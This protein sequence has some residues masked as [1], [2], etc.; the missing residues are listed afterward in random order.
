MANETTTEPTRQDDEQTGEQAKATFDAVPAD[1][2]FYTIKL[3]IAPD[4]NEITGLGFY[5]GPV[6]KALD[7][8]REKVKE[9]AQVVRLA[10]IGM[11][12]AIN[13]ANMHAQ[14]RQLAKEFLK[15]FTEGDKENGE[16]TSGEGGPTEPGQPTERADSVSGN[17]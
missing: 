4:S 14:A 13:H 16:Q 1:R 2:T 17:S 10:G 5:D 12:E 7:L 6:L 11:Q 3:F 8:P 15:M 9:C